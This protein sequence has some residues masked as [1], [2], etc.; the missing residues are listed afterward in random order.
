MI[1]DWKS[2]FEARYSETVV[3]RWSGRA[4]IRS[5]RCDGKGIGAP[6]AIK[7]GEGPSSLRWA[8]GIFFGGHAVIVIRYGCRW[9]KSLG[10]WA[11]EPMREGVSK[12]IGP[13][14]GGPLDV[15]AASKSSP[16]SFSLKA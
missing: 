15:V 13:G 11:A 10:L 1:E 4:W 8:E 12:K 6:T 14:R 5:G 2:R 16:S 7:R 9:A 3:A